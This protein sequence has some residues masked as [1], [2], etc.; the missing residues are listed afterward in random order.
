VSAPTGPAGPSGPLGPSDRNPGI[1]AARVAA[2]AAI[3]LAHFK[4]WATGGWM[5]LYASVMEV[6][7]SQGVPVF[8]ALSGYLFKPRPER[9]WPAFLAGRRYLLP[10]AVCAT[11]VYLF[12]VTWA[13]ASYDPA[14]HLTYALGAESIYFYLT[15]LFVFEL[16]TRAI[17]TLDRA[18][19]AGAALVLALV[20]TTY[21]AL[22]VVHNPNGYYMGISP[23][24]LLLNPF[25]FYVYYALG[26]LLAAGG[27]VARAAVSRRGLWLAAFL[28]LLGLNV[29]GTWGLVSHGR[30]W[31]AYFW[32]GQVL[33]GAAGV[34]AAHGWMVAP[35]RPGWL[36]A[37]LAPLGVYAFPVYL[38]HGIP[39]VLADGWFRRAG[40]PLVPW[41]LVAVPVMIAAV[42]AGAAVV[43]RVL[44][45][46]LS[47]ALIGV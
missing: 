12:I 16:F 14:R 21:A 29:A 17:R 18:R 22:R 38:L 27:A 1:E 9:S 46:R 6:V 39:V 35:A 40:I 24:V 15:L 28:V 32:P 33:L 30:P 37:R 36:T 19:V 5:N 41:H 11:A 3:V 25:N 31:L 8:F 20:S 47:R 7:S 4:P 2:L 43:R 13:G 26:R 45:G 23:F 34:L 10:W 42:M 44:P